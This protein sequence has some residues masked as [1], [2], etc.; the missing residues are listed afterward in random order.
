MVPS[1]STPDLQSFPLTM[2][3]GHILDPDGKELLKKISG[4]ILHRITQPLIVLDQQGVSGKIKYS[5]NGH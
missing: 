4:E 2:L 3:V 1:T 5:K